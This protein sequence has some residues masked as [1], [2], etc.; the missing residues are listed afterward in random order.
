[1]KP[2]FKVITKTLEHTEAA[3][4]A[5]AESNNVISFQTN[6]FRGD[7]N[8]VMQTTTIMYTDKTLSERGI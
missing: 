2:K 6:I 7:Y 1:M 3:L 4:A 5:F 8:V